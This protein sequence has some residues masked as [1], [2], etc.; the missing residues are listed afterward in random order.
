MD[1]PP[2]C[3]EPFKLS[4]FGLMVNATFCVG[5]ILETLGICKQ[6]TF[7][8]NLISLLVLKKDPTL[9][10][11]DAQFG[12]VPVRIYEPKSSS[13]EKRRCVIFFHGGLCMFGTTKCYSYVCRTIARESESIVIDIEYR[14][15][16]AHPFP[17]QKI[18][19][20]TVLEHIQK[21]AE[22]YGVDPNRIIL[23]G[24]SSGGTMAAAVCHILVAMKDVVK[25]RAQ[26]LIYPLLQSLDF[27]LPSYQQNKSIPMLY[28]KRAV[29]LG[30][31]YITEDT[32]DFDSI[33]NG[34]H[35]PDELRVRY[36]K[37]IS[38]HHIPDEFKVRGYVPLEPAPFSK[39]L[40]EVCKITFQA[41][42]SPLLV[43][44]GIIRQ[45]PETLLLTCEYDVLRDD[46]LLYKKRLEDNGVPVTWLHLK[47]GF[48]GIMFEGDK[49]PFS[50][51]DAK[52][53]W[54]SIASFIKKF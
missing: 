53:A 50:F 42:F 6:M 19:C 45:V 21:E 49:M 52:P 33:I 7:V 10:I 3:N 25:P 35:V 5:S 22:N 15:A 32:V 29:K 51:K 41:D 26:V 17:A 37:W 13:S 31:K 16:P 36:R 38:A 54:E 40:Y 23:A 47:N 12:H 46:G 4:F 20:I 48:H 28:R 39:K 9:H 14:L 43:E 1:I 30:V 11:R 34:A 24:D 2:D 44:D 18:D 8:R 27:S